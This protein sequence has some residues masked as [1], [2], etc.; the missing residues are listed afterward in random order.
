MKKII[1]KIFKIKIIKQYEY[2][3]LIDSIIVCGKVYRKYSNNK[4]HTGNEK[5]EIYLN[6][7]NNICFVENEVWEDVKDELIK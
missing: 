7:L 1:E 5:V 3:R 4:Y 6:E 2:R